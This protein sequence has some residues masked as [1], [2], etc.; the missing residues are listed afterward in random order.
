MSWKTRVCV[1]T[2]VKKFKT[3]RWMRLLIILE[4]VCLKLYYCGNTRDKACNRVRIDLLGFVS[5]ML[6]YF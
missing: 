4:G 2:C 6:V 1:T 5:G 3:L